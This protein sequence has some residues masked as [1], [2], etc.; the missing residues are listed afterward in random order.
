VSIANRDAPHLQEAAM[1][2]EF[3]TFL[4]VCRWGTFTAAAQHLG[5]TQSAVSDHMQRLEEFTGVQLFHRTGRSATLNAAGE[6]LRPLAEEA[7]QITDRMRTGRGAGQLRGSLRVGAITSV[8]NSLMARALVAFRKAH[9]AVTIRLIRREGPM[10]GDVEREE[11]D[12]AASVM[13][14][15][16]SLRTIRWIPLFRKPFVLIAPAATRARNWREAMAMH[17]FMGYDLSWST[18]VQIDDFLTR[19]GVVIRDSLSVDYLD[20]MITL[21]A[22]G[23]GVAI[24]PRTPLGEASGLVREFEFGTDTFHRE[25]GLVRRA[26]PPNGGAIADAFIDTLL[27]EVK[28]EPFAEVI[29]A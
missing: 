17:T 7:L 5:M 16:A 6:A 18:G 8:H 4:A 11:F 25:V 28:R 1:L 14:N 20:T 13:P 2:R 9:P 12:L 24:I 19:M 22:G 27:V 15:L 29:G 21:V 23:V 26:R 3:Q 10:A